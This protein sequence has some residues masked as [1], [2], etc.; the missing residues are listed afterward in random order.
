MAV[1]GR[2]YVPSVTLVPRNSIFL[3]LALISITGLVWPEGLG[4]LQNIMGVGINSP[5]PE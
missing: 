4:K 1:N 2:P 3:L 5:T